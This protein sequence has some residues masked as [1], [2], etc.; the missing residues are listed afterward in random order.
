MSYLVEAGGQLGPPRAQPVQEC[1][2][3]GEPQGVDPC[4]T[5]GMCGPRA[6]L[7]EI[8]FQGSGL[9]VPLAG[10]AER[11]LES[12]STP[13]HCCVSSDVLAPLALV[14]D[15]KVTGPLHFAIICGAYRYIYWQAASATTRSS[16]YQL[17]RKPKLSSGVQL[18]RLASL[19]LATKFLAPPLEG[20][21]LSSLEGA[22]TVSIHHTIKNR[23]H[24]PGMTACCSD[25]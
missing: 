25:Q 20:S 7:P 9:F 22:N 5:C 23:P 12:D 8:N 3:G 1:S 11:F 2:A 10:C 18:P 13:Y 17:Q 24:L 16:V 6:R 14:G 4:G 19:R 21:W 15:M